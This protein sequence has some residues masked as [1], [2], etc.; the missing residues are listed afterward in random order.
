M[1]ACLLAMLTSQNCCMPLPDQ[2]MSFLSDD[3]MLETRGARIRGEHVS[4]VPRQ[5]GRGSRS[6]STACPTCATPRT[7]NWVGGGLVVSRWLSLRELRTRESRCA[8]A[9]ATSSILTMTDASGARILEGCPAVAAATSKGC[10]HGI[11]GGWRN[12]RPQR[13]RSDVGGVPRSFRAIARSQP[14]GVQQT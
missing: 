4:K 13:A 3:C 10:R 11:P 7:S 6:A 14:S 8:W 2:I 12:P 5:R 9:A 1:A